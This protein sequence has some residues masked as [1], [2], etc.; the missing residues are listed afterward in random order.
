[1]KTRL[2][3][4]LPCLA[5]LVAFIPAAA[6]HAETYD[7]VG[8]SGAGS[9]S[10]TANWTPSGT[11]GAGDTIIQNSNGGTN[12]FVRTDTRN[13]SVSAWT[14]TASGNFNIYSTNSSGVS[15]TLH[16]SGTLTAQQSSGNLVV[17]NS[18]GTL[19]LTLG[20]LVLD[21]A[22]NGTTTSLQLGGWNTTGPLE[23]LSVSGSTTIKSSSILYLNVT[24]TADLGT[25]IWDDA[26]T[27][28]I[29]LHAGAEGSDATPSVR[30]V[31]VAS[32]SS[33][34][35]SATI[36][37]AIGSTSRRVAT[38]DIS[39]TAG[40]TTFAGQLVNNAGVNTNGILNVTKSGAS[41]QILTGAS[42]YSGT[43]AVTGGKLVVNGA[44]TGA[45][46]YSVSNYG[47]LAGSGAI[48]TA[49][50][51]DIVI[52]AGGRLSPGDNGAGSLTFA[53]GSGKLDLAQAGASSLLFTLGAPGHGTSVS[54]TS[55][56]IDIGSGNI[57]LASFDFSFTAGFGTG[58]YT[59]FSSTQSV[60]GTLGSNL[61]GILNG[62]EVTL[63]LSDDSKSIVLNVGSPAIPE[64]G[65][66]AFLV[67][68]STFLCALV[69]R[70]FRF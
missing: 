44:H 29:Y 69:F 37:G 8:G 62:Y 10:S 41:T 50:N 4:L 22:G 64:P 67:A 6:L 45:G 34:N 12:N 35:A 63:A 70:H 25:L 5:S 7:W 14:Y 57:N 58:T 60:V 1:M 21:F 59:L 31:K 17:R 52:G 2:T 16:I 49:S 42:T 20:N 23:G 54:V 48:T 15:D 38:L 36:S 30:T 27:G 43:T 56:T 24:N 53:L 66:V 26:S 51:N 39:G 47:I 11:P 32:L 18:G 65:M 13:R 9:W 68:I 40:T 19:N 46:A 55:G 28:A 33:T 3:K 61:T